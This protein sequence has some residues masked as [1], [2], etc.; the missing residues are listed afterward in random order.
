MLKPG[1]DAVGSGRGAGGFARVRWVS[2][3]GSGSKFAGVDKRD[4][5]AD[6]GFGVA[7]GVQRVF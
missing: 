5:V 3:P 4:G 2:R 1:A 6:G 7:V